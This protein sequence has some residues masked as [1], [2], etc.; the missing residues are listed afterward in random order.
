MSIE[1]QHPAS[2]P[3]QQVYRTTSER[4]VY[5]MVIML[6]ICIVGGIIFFSMWDYWISTPAPV[7]AM[8]AGEADLAAPATATGKTITQDLTF[9]ES[10]DFRTLAFNALPGEDDNNPTVHMNVG[11]TVVFNVDNGGISFHA[12]GVTQGTEGIAGIIPGSEIGTMSNALKP[13]EGGSS[14]FIAGEEGTYYYICT[15]PGHREQGMVGEI[16]VGPAQGGGSSGKAA[17][18]TGVSHEFTFNFVES[19]DFRTLAFN[20]L[21]GEDGHNPEIRVNSGDE[22]TITANNMGKSFHA[23]GVVSNPEDFNSV[24]WDSAIAAMAN[25]LKPGE[26]GSTTF[27]AGAPGTYYYICTVPGHALQ[28]MQGSFIVE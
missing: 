28:G 1:T 26:G 8:M 19:D 25:P 2:D 24:I 16:I 14:E 20:A 15:V 9:I 18:P 12:F 4:T 3:K 23:F 22:V 17:A 27:I 5:M 11:D 10:S 13:G 6:G 7:V 21:P